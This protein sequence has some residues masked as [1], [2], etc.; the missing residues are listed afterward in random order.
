MQ[1]HGEVTGQACETLYETYFPIVMARRGNGIISAMFVFLRVL[2]RGESVG[3]WLSEDLFL[4]PFSGI[5]F[6]AR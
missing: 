1:R 3:M 6:A 2:W 5:P 4:S